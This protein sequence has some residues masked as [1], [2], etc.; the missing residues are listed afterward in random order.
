[1]DA[2]GKMREYVDASAEDAVADIRVR[3]EVVGEGS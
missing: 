3:A 2:W 1:M